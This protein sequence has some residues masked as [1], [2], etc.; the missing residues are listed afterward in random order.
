MYPFIDVISGGLTV[1]DWFKNQCM[2]I[3]TQK[4]ALRLLSIV[5]NQL[6]KYEHSKVMSPDVLKKMKKL[7]SKLESKGKSLLSQEFIENLDLDDYQIAVPKKRPSR[8]DLLK[9]RHAEK[10]S[11]HDDEV[12]VAHF[13]P[14]ESVEFDINKLVD[15]NHRRY[16]MD[17]FNDI[18][19][20]MQLQEAFGQNPAVSNKQTDS[21]KAKNAKNPKMRA[22]YQN[23]IK[24]RIDAEKIILDKVKNGELD[25]KIFN[26]ANIRNMKDDDVFAVAG[27]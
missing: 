6:H 7:E 14:S 16:T 20:D 22:V 10:K 23:K 15:E 24:N 11:K 12:Y 27:N 4:S 26:P 5:R 9:M 13:E 3:G 21:I 19:E 18:Y 2:Y 17:E 25:A 1:E 8:A